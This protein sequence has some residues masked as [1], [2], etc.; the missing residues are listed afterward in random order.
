MDQHSGLG[1][2]C[3]WEVIENQQVK[4]ND[5]VMNKVIIAFSE[6]LVNAFYKK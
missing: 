2:I 4:V 5:E 3:L 1:V 6:M